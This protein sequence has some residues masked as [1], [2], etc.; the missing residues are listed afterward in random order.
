[1]DQ[2]FL[3]DGLSEKFKLTIPDEDARNIR[4]V[5]DAI[6]YIQSHKN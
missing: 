5:G 1:M 2:F 3:I 4:S 6:D